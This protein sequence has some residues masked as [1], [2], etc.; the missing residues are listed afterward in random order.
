MED[1]AL[2][3]TA[4]LRGGQSQN[5][6]SDAEGKLLRQ[7]QQP[8][9]ERG[10]GETAKPPQINDPLDCAA[11]REGSIWVIARG[12]DDSRAR[13]VQQWSA[14]GELLRRLAIAP[15]DPEPV[16]IAASPVADRIYLLEENAAV[17][18][19][20]ALTLLATKADGGQA[21][22]DWKVE[23]EKKISPHKNF[24]VS[25]GKL[26]IAGGDPKPVEPVTVK[27]QPNPLQ[28]DERATVEI[29]AGFDADSSFVKT[30]DGLP[31]QTISETPGLSRVIAAR[32]G[33]KSL[34]V[35]QD[36]DAVVEQ[37]RISGLDQMMA[38]DCGEFELK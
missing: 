29:A 14:S 13:E 28:K 1:D 21:V 9:R 26:V 25:D 5:L 10:C 6:I 11:G 31:L 2:V 20:R 27:L 36:D 19:L 3:V 24:A 12:D 34:D 35:F 16:Q 17:Q 4:K 23:F 18:R 7:T 8:V 15:E 32:A 38:V 22:S 37:F 30:A 33:E